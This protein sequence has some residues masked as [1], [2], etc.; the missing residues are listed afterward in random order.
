M[1]A[2]CGYTAGAESV[3]LKALVDMDA[4]TTIMTP[5]VA[6]YFLVPEVIRL[7]NSHM[8]AFKVGYFQVPVQV[9]VG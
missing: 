6:G 7:G 2:L 9:W 3:K 5:K 1:A 8:I 4:E